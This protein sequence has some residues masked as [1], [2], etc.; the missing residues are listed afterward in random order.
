M[1]TPRR[2]VQRA[3]IPIQK[4]QRDHGFGL[5]LHLDSALFGS[6]PS[7]IAQSKGLCPS[8]AQALQYHV[9]CHNTQAF[10]Q[11]RK[12]AGSRAGRQAGKEAVRQAGTHT[13][14]HVHA[15]ALLPFRTCTTVLARVRAREHTQASAGT[16]ARMCACVRC[17]VD[18]S[19]VHACECVCVS[20]VRVC[21]RMR[22]CAR[23]VH[24]RIP[25]LTS[26]T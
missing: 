18:R 4:Q 25:E 10:R 14:E 16:R 1:K 11:A 24:V 26:A 9:E 12:A 15:R 5:R 19:H 2:Q 20:Y 17:R 3:T 13:R 6:C 8:S 7:P 23:R 22:A 21:V